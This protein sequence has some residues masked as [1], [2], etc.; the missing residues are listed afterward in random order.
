MKN[1]KIRNIAVF[2]I[3]IFV[4]LSC[5]IPGSIGSIFNYD[6]NNSEDNNVIIASS[7]VITSLSSDYSSI[8]D[9]LTIYGYGF[10]NSE[11]YIVLTGLCVEPISWTNTQIT[12]KIPRIGAS[13]YIYIR[14][15]NST[16]SNSVNFKV[17]RSLP[18][19]QFE[20]YG[21]SL[22]DTGILG[23]A[24]LVETDGSYVYG[25][26]GYDT[27]STYKIF[28]DSPYELKNR[29]YLPQRINELR[30]FDNYLFLTG[31][32]GLFVYRC[33]DLQNDNPQ[34]VIAIA[35]AAIMALDIKEIN[36]DPIDGVLLALCEYKSWWDSDIL[37]ISF[38]K[39][40]NEELIE[41]GSFQRK[42]DNVKERQI[43]IA[44]DPINPKVYVSGYKTLLGSDK[45]ILEI[46]ISKIESPDLNHREEL[47]N[48]LPFD[49]ETINDRLWSGQ[50]HT[51][52]EGFRAY[53]LYPGEDYLTLDESIHTKFML[54]KTTRV[55]II[56]DDVSVGSSWLGERPDVFIWNTFN[57]GSS[58]SASE[59]SIDWAFDITGYS[60]STGSYDG[61]IIVADEWGGFLTYEYQ[62]S[63]SYSI[64]HVKNYHHV[65]TG[66]MTA[67]IHLTDERV[68]IAGRGGGVWSADKFDLS[69]ESKWRWGDWDFSLENPQPHPVSSL[70]TREDPDLG[71]II[72][73]RAHNKAFAWGSK[74]YG[75][76]YQE[77]N[78]GITELAISEEIEPKTGNIWVDMAWPYTDLV[79]MPT[80]DD[81]FRALVINPDKPS[82]AIH[83]DCLEVGFGND[84]FSNT[85]HS[86]TIQ[87]Y[88]DS[89]GD[90]IIVASESSIFGGESGLFVF[91]VS[92]P[93]GIPDRNSPDRSIV[94]KKENSLNCLK[95][96]TVNQMDVT[97][98]GIISVATPQGIGIFHISWIPILN[99][100]SNTQAW[101]LIKVPLE[102]YEPWWYDGW[103]NGLDDVSF[104]TDNEI[105]VLKTKLGIWKLEI[106]IDME[107]YTHQSVCT[108][109]YPG[110]GG[111]IDYENLL[112][113]WGNPDIPT[114]HH[115]YLLDVDNN[116]A[117]VTGWLGKIQKVT[118]IGDNSPP[119]PPTI[120]GRVEGKVGTEYTYVFNS[121]DIDGDM[122]SYYIEWGDGNSSGWIGPFNSG[123]DITDKHIWSEGGIYT[124]RAKSKDIYG[125]EGNWGTLT[126]TMPRNRLIY[127]KLIFWF[128]EQFKNSFPLLRYI[129]R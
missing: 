40:D 19:F 5:I 103:N 53:Q 68:Y 32:M 66:A 54:G 48:L 86:G 12:F 64:N 22:I 18:D 11:G 113:G 61:K 97:S 102:T 94:I 74:T 47:A 27:L 57:S 60:E 83:K 35:N 110:I 75:I 100:M 72:V 129:L 17:L 7:P 13:G 44:I 52:T 43:A 39:F 101:N 15:I 1:N 33:S 79:Y 95:Y 46:N 73:G 128:F 16:K 36:G 34:I 118:Y 119:A 55:K 77:T 24:L 112:F 96:K 117:Y 42:E 107:N 38:F 114:L 91:S 30:I 108:S 115:P 28:E 14:D 90:K 49:M 29:I 63:P 56:D 87:Y 4:V 121:I 124:I 98:T 85:H 3:F 104:N 116:S 9:L 76:L 10:G 78:D 6:N 111:G 2:F 99:N 51:G 81:G 21:L 105:F 41:L 109:Y 31:D 89:N 20:P 126:V 92:Y 123:E 80:G 26:T 23:P 62:K 45:Y 125:H 50:V 37:H 84:N 120:T 67:G 69:D 59:E 122:V 82:I 25:V 70:C 93:E 106:E 71:T 88:K 58:P 65:P 8:G 127:N